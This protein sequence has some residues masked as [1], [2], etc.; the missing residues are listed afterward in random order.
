M[1]VLHVIGSLIHGGAEAV[2][3]RLATHG[4][5]ATHHV[6]S[7]GPPAHYSPLLAE[8]GVEVDH[9]GAASA[10]GSLRAVASLRRIVKRTR[11]DV[12]Q[13]W[14]Y[15]SNLVAGLVGKTTGTPVVWSIHCAS[16]SQLGRRAKMW[17]YLCGATARW[18][19]SR[20]VNCS[21]SS[22]ELH[23]RI[24]FDAA[25]TRVI[26]NGVDVG[27]FSP[28]EEARLRAR[29]KLGIAPETFLVGT[30]ARWHPQKGHATLLAALAG[31]PERM[32]GG[33]KCLLVGP[34]MDAGNAPLRRMVEEAGVADRVI[35]AGPRTDVAE[36]MRALDLHVLSS[37]EE[38]VSAT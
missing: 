7:F 34:W 15:R 35:L 4:S 27:I 30:V 33:W 38:V 37:W 9:L 1:R 19:P 29:A 8:R 22:V 14:M 23:A 24:G 28:D 26:P 20:I 6:V 21:A 5:D 12:I 17:I 32:R 13:T 2:L 10:G 25:R 11:P 31:L 36:V 18:L 3:Y 16:F